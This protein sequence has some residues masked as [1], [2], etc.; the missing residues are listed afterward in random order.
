LIRGREREQTRN[1]TNFAADESIGMS[2]LAAQII[3]ETYAKDFSGN[4]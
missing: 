2:A 1:E 4:A 3:M